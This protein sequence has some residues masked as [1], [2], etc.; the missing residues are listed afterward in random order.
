MRKTT[1]KLGVTFLS[2]TMLLSAA[3]GVAN[4]ATL[5]TQTAIGKY[6]QSHQGDLGNP[7]TDEQKF[8]NGASAQEFEHGL[9]TYSQRTGTRTLTNAQE[10][11]AFKNAGGV[12]KFGALE[13]DSWNNTFCGQSVTTFDGKTRWMVVVDAKTQ[14]SSS[15][16]LN[17]A[18]GNQ[19]K[20]DR[21]K[22]NA[23]FPD[24]APVV[25]QPTEPTDPAQPENLV[26]NLDWS[27]AT[28][29]QYKNALLLQTD[30]TA[31]VTAADANGVRVANAPVYEV[32]WLKTNEAARQVWTW[33]NYN[34]GKLSL[35]GL[36]IAPATW[37]GNTSTQTFDYGT[38]TW[39]RG[40]ER[41][42]VELTQEGTVKLESAAQVHGYD[43]RAEG[44]TG[45][46]TPLDDRF[47]IE[48]TS[49]FIFVYDSKADTAGWMDP[50]VFDEFVKDPDRFGTIKYSGSI[51]DGRGGPIYNYMI[52]Y[53]DEPEGGETQV[54]GFMTKSVTVSSDR[55]GNYIIDNEPE[56]APLTDPATVDWSKYATLMGN[57]QAL[58]FQDGDSAL[59]I[60]ANP[61]GTPKMGA[62]A[63]RSDVLGFQMTRFDGRWDHN[64]ASAWVYGSPYTDEI[65]NAGALG[66]PL[67]DGRYVEEN[68][69]KYYLQ[70]FE[71]GSIKWAVPASRLIESDDSKVEITLNALGEARL[72]ANDPQLPAV[73]G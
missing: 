26:A 52:T 38:V 54:T 10:I 27:K 8:A 6:V 29:V 53:F 36:P 56:L 5:N 28:Y 41:P 61:D 21:V 14:P 39:T 19:W 37:N 49:E 59:I 65:T 4:A 2:A 66:L 40:S 20:K 16:D 60:A 57:Q 55:D 42:T 73:N 3:P 58:Y 31:Y 25:D 46:L 11:Q 30:T 43:I 22:T 23:C 51:G 50:R 9:V 13:S 35:L 32:E 17:S 34:S 70:D 64:F 45:N 18:E 71:G 48:K 68:G 7:V 72:A 1:Q 67:A 69:Q 62:K 33:E 24:N 12:E 44:Y 15:V 63:V 47:L